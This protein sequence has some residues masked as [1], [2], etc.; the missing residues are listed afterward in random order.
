MYIVITNILSL[1]CRDFENETFCAARLEAEVCDC[2]NHGELCKMTCSCCK[3][4]QF[5]EKGH[6]TGMLLDNVFVEL[7]V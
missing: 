2:R 3:L 4:T 1:A 7:N 6:E 5:V